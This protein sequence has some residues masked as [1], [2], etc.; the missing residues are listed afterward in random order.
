MHFC[1]TFSIQTSTLCTISWSQSIINF[2]E[3]FK[4]LMWFTVVAFALSFLMH[5]GVSP[6][7]RIVCI[8][9]TVP[10]KARRPVEKRRVNTAGQHGGEKYPPTPYCVVLTQPQHGGEKYTPPSCPF[11]CLSDVVIV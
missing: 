1:K 4:E 5:S 6:F 9:N 7:K 2:C 8:C 10:A 3:R 11:A